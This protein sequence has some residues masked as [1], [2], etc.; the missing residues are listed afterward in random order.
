MASLLDAS[1][2]SQ[3][4]QA[5]IETDNP[6]ALIEELLQRLRA[7]D[8]QFCHWK[9]NRGLPNALAANEDLDI[10]AARSCAGQFTSTLAELGFKQVRSGPDREFPGIEDHIGFDAP[11]GKIVHLQLHYRLIL[12]EPLIKNFLFPIET[13]M[14]EDLDF[15]NGMPIP[16]P[17]AE[18]A[19]FTLRILIK[20]KPY[21][22]LK[23]AVVDLLR[24]E[25][26]KEFAFLRSQENGEQAAVLVSKF[27]SG[28]PVD[29]FMACLTAIGSGASIHEILGLRRQVLRILGAYRRRSRVDT[30]RSL[31]RRRAFLS[32][33][34][35][36]R[37]RVPKR[38]PA[39]GGLMIA[40]VGPDGS[41]KSTAIET[42]DR[43]LSPFVNITL[44]HMGKPPKDIKSA[45]VGRLVSL[46]R[47]LTNAGS[48]PAR[49]P[50]DSE[51]TAGAGL[52]TLYAWQLACLARDRKRESER[53][54]RA[55]MSGELVLCDRYP[56]PN[57]HSME[58]SHGHR[59][60]KARGRL[61][62]RWIRMEKEIH[63]SLERPGLVIGLR[64]SP[65]T[66]S[67]RQ[68]GDGADFVSFRAEEF[69]AYTEDHA[70]DMVTLDASA[71]LTDVSQQLRRLVWQAL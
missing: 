12:G 24:L 15:S 67:R 46:A 28:F 31:L 30:V 59:L 58:G 34:Q 42:I 57:L 63:D 26:R 27:F 22:V 54:F 2:T 55:A 45:I 3:R 68:P 65:E 1:G 51:I 17:A 43:W 40:I 23:P 47:R 14:L 18:L 66:A 25:A 16:V 19:I 8:V 44:G 6:I 71:T 38:T 13:E 69:F 52:Q 62:R 48:L 35:R 49:I 29:L 36:A 32:N 64:V 9:S 61:A 56:M 60:Q 41:G 7:S 11:S 50:A 70:Q 21:H 10:L 4:V 33:W 5:K 39:S 53:L 37:G 20:F